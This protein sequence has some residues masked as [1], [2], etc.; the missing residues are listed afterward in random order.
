MKGQD[1]IL[2]SVKNY[3]AIHKKNLNANH[4]SPHFQITKYI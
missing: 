3:L 4:K 1:N 2:P